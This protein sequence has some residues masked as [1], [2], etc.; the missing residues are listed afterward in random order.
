M[1][2]RDQGIEDQRTGVGGQGTQSLATNPQPPI[3]KSYRDLEV[4]QKAMDLAVDCYKLTE[5]FPTDE[6]YGLCS[7]LQRA[8]AS[9]PANIA[10]GH[11]RH[12]TK[13]FLQFVSVAKGSLAELET[14]LIL[15]NRLAYIE[16]NGLEVMLEKTSTLGRMLNGLQRS[17]RR[18]VAKK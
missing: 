13:E 8:A 9:I 17:L 15:A 1:G 18:R 12:H 4:W 16:G 2:F 7:Q 5:K 14:H 11:S 3:I 6:K 10:E